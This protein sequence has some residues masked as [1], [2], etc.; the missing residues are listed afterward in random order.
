MNLVANI[1]FVQAF[2]DDDS[3]PKFRHQCFY[4]VLEVVLDDLINKD[5]PFPHEFP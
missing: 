3:C 4:T 2:S 5:P 1:K